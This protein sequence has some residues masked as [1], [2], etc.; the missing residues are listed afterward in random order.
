MNGIVYERTRKKKAKKM[1]DVQC[2]RHKRITD[3]VA[4][5]KQVMKKRKRVDI[6]TVPDTAA[7]AMGF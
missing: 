5:V 7:H 3:G 2:L 6:I 1:Q 4:W